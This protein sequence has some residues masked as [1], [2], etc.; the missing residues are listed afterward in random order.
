MIILMFLSQAISIWEI[1]QCSGHSDLE[2]E[3]FFNLVQH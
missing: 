3:I 2:I 1:K